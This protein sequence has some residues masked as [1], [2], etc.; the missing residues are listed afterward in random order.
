[1]KNVCLKI[2]NIY[3][4]LYVTDENCGMRNVLNPY[5]WDV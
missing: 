1:M 5:F 4:S 3:A 2:P